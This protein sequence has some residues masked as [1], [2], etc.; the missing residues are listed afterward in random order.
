MGS[1]GEEVPRTR[2]SPA[3]IAAKVSGPL[4]G[5]SPPP[6]SLQGQCQASQQLAFGAYS[7]HPYG[8]I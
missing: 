7:V 4:P 2:M 3:T 1:S 8:T 5:Y 6:S